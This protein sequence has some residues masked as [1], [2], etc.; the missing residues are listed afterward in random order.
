MGPDGLAAML[1][2]AVTE[3]ITV[4]IMIFEE[5]GLPD[6]QF[7]ELVISQRIWSELTR[8]LSE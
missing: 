5:A 6:T 1:T 3:G 4:V 8:V 2:P 7:A